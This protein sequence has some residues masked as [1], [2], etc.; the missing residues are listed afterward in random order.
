MS[1]STIQGPVYTNH[2]I[3]TNLVFSPDPLVFPGEFNVSFQAELKIDVPNNL[4]AQVQLSKRVGSQDVPLP[5]VANIGSCV[6]DDLC[7]I[8]S[9][10]VC[11]REFVT[12]GV[13]CKCPF[14]AGTYNLP[15]ATF[16]VFAAFLLPG[17]YTFVVNLTHGDIYLGCYKLVATFA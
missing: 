5:C 6:Y 4:K 8:L 15:V 14:K 2:L 1:T 10:V 9:G 7:S 13:P 12:A 17:V 11:P 3:V 16:R